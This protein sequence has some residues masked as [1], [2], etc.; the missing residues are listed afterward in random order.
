MEEGKNCREKDLTGLATEARTRKM[1]NNG[2][3]RSRLMA[4]KHDLENLLGR[5]QVTQKRAHTTYE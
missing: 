4:D 1:A 5:R 3:E 2:G